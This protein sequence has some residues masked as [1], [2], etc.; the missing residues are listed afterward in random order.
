MLDASQSMN[1]L[2]IVKFTFV[3]ISNKKPP[4]KSRF[5]DDHDL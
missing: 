1:I 5:L 4:Q 3:L 2:K